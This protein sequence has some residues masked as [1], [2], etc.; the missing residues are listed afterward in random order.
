MIGINGKGAAVLVLVVAVLLAGIYIAYPFVNNYF[1]GDGDGG[2]EDT[3]VFDLP[4]EAF[5]GANP[6]L[7]I[8]AGFGAGG[9]PIGSADVW[10][11]DV[12]IILMSYNPGVYG[13]LG[14]IIGMKFTFYNGEAV[15]GTAVSEGD[16]LALS[17]G[18]AKLY[19]EE[20]GMYVV[21]C[22]FAGIDDEGWDCDEIAPGS[23]FTKITAEVLVYIGGGEKLT[24]LTLT[25]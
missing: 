5:V 7:E 11:G 14:N 19:K 2:E 16:D 4:N 21:Q 13:Q 17:I 8:N 25:V 20:Y 9:T 1:N 18:M 10:N 23:I 3:T 24:K 12:G 6:L 22:A 15:V